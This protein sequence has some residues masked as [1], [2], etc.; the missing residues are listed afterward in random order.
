MTMR[1]VIE[2]DKIWKQYRLGMIGAGA[3]TDDMRRL[4]ARISGKE[5]PTAKLG[6]VNNREDAR[7]SGYVWAL[8]DISFSLKQGE[9]LGIIGSNGAGKSTLLKL[10][11]Q[12]A[13]PTKGNIRIK[14]RVASL[15]EVGTGFHP[16]L[17][18]RDNIYLNGAILGMRKSE[19]DKSFDDIVDFS[20][21]H[22]YIDTPVKRYSSGMKVRLGFAVAAHLEPEI[23]VV[24]EVLAVGDAEFQARCLK[25]MENVAGSGRTILFVSHNLSAVRNLCSRGIVIEQGGLVYDGPA[26]DAIAHYRSRVS[27]D[28]TSVSHRTFPEIS[29]V[30][31]Q[32]TEATVVSTGL[33]HVA[34]FEFTEKVIVKAEIFIHVPAADHMLGVIVEDSA[35]NILIVSTNDEANGT[36]LANLPAGRHIVMIEIPSGILKPGNYTITLSARGRTGK[37]YHKV[38]QALSFNIVDTITF[39]GMK[40]LYRKQALVAPEISWNLIG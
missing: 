8:R 9:T 37:A 15:L 23:L 30:P 18:G 3:L 35:G 40:N 27:S 5:D 22:K 19:I 1:N 13:F 29:N 38:E 10:L 24:D 21:V 25:K 28:D 33:D 26:S 34:V 7:T 17:T 14:G 20:G 11:S 2:V 36:F 6:E 12:V 16:D 39:R 32:F 31:M 4:W